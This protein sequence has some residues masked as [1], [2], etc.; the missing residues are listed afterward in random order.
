M[1]H[2]C[3]IVEALAADAFRL[4]GDVGAEVHVGGVPPDEEGLTLSMSV[5]DELD[6]AIGDI[7]IDGLHAFFGQWTGVF[8][9]LLPN[10]TETWVHG[11]IIDI[12]G[13]AVHHTTRAKALPELW[14]LGI[15]GML[16]LFLGVEMVKV[17]IEF[18]KT[19]D[20][21]QE[22]IAVAQMVLAKLSGNIALRL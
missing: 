21:G 1:Q 17:A 3:I 11:R 14:I 9:G 18:I 7:V 5:P 19:V 15:V 22:L 20:R 2:H 12:G 13:F 4:L 16:R 10:T 8:N 6:R